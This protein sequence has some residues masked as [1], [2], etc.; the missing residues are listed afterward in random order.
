MICIFSH[1]DDFLI[2]IV[3]C[4]VHTKSQGS[5]DEYL[6]KLLGGASGFTVVTGDQQELKAALDASAR[7]ETRSAHSDEL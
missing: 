5:I 6:D 4:P 2:H 3:H 1:D 7:S